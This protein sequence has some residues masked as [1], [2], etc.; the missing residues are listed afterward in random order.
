MGIVLGY[1][2]EC[3]AATPE[4]EYNCYSIDPSTME[5]TNDFEN[6]LR[7]IETEPLECTDGEPPFFIYSFILEWEREKDSYL[8]ISQ[9]HTYTREF[10]PE[11]AV[12]GTIYTSFSITTPT[13]SPTPTPTPS[14]T[15]EAS[16]VGKKLGLALVVVAFLAVSSILI[17][18]KKGH[19][20]GK[21]GNENLENK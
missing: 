9:A 15:M 3:K 16:S 14:P 1:N 18:C 10:N 2:Q 12:Q 13:L 4:W 8:G 6:F 5:T 17:S 19:G 20:C 21:I 7:K 11:F